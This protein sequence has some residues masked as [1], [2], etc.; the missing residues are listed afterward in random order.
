MQK[1]EQEVYFTLQDKHSFIKN[2]MGYTSEKFFNTILR[3]DLQDI[4]I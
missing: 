2:I 4:F 1:K 3:T